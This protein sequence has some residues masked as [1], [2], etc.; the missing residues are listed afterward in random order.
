MKVFLIFIL[1]SI[2]FLGKAQWFELNSNS[3]NTLN[4]IAFKNSREGYAVGNNNETLHTTNEGLTWAKENLSSTTSDKN[5]YDL[6][7]T[8]D[9]IY[10]FFEEFGIEKRGLK[11][12]KSTN[13]GESWLTIDD[14]KVN[15]P[16]SAR[17]AC[18]I[19]GSIGYVILYADGVNLSDVVYHIRK[20]TDGGANWIDVSYDLIEKSQAK[21]IAFLN[22]NIGVVAGENNTVIYTL[23]GGSSWNSLMISQAPSA[24][25]TAAAFT[26]D[27]T[28]YLVGNADN[29]GV[30]ARSKD[31]GMTWDITSTNDPI[32]AI[33]FL[34]NSTGYAVGNNG[35]ILITTDSGNTWVSQNSNTSNVLLD[36][37]IIDEN[38]KVYVAGKNGTILVNEELDTSIIAAFTPVTTGC[39]DNLI[40]FTNTSFNANSYKWYIENELVSTDENLQYTFDSAGLYDVKLVVDSSNTHFDSISSAI[41]IY[42]SPETDFSLL[43]SASQLIGDTVSLGTSIESDNQ[44]L[45]STGQQWYINDQLE[46]TT[47]NFNKTLN[48]SGLIEITLIA[49]QQDICFDTSSQNIFVTGGS[50]GIDN[51]EIS[52]LIVYPNPIN[53]TFNIQLSGINIGQNAFLQIENI[54]GQIVF[55]KVINNSFDLLNITVNIPTGI[56]NLSLFNNNYLYVKKIVNQ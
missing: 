30:I 7:I 19:N 13:G 21:A 38:S 26:S 14:D 50:T 42:T 36:I 10:C 49:N 41:T 28:L 2:T 9:T 6:D 55:R 39:T 18:F 25:Y 24:S 56:Y 47:F 33:D 20:T 37:A 40:I 34:N 52:N 32:Q 29:K 12:L 43:D 35:S 17:E 3:T 54:Y 44:T 45:N 4:S 48:T 53:N 23:N 27:S 8:G 1:S 46:F 15:A 22:S 5:Y 31:L 51:N 11:Y 16:N